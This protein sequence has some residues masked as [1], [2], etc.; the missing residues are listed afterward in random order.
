MKFDPNKIPM[1]PWMAAF[2]MIAAALITLIVGLEGS[3]K[4]LYSIAGIIL[5]IGLTTAVSTLI[6]AY[7]QNR[8]IHS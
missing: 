7:L 4:T 8:S 5:G 1:K 2:A 3:Y 6:Y